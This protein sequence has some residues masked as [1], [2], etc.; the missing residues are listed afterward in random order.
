MTPKITG[1]L[2]SNDARGNVG[3][4][5]TYSKTF[6]G[7]IAKRTPKRKDLPSDL[8]KAYREVYKA[9]KDEWKSLTDEEK[10][11][12]IDMADGKPRT[13]FNMFMSEYMK[14]HAGDPFLG[15]YGVA[16]YDVSLYYP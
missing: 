4:V 12:Y 7:N 9:G 3:K 16:I 1:P 11:V 8:Q 14:N 10:Q 5:I 2:F 15:L 6:G 13:G